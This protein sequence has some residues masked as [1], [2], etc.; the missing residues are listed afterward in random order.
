MKRTFTVAVATLSLALPGLL[1]ST[2]TAQAASGDHV[3]INEAYLNGGSGG[4]TYKNKY[5]ELYNPTD[6]AVSLTG[7]SLQ[8][9]SAS[10]TSG[11]SGV[12]ALSGSIP[13]KGY[14]VVAG[15]YNTTTP[16]GADWTASVTPDISTSVSWS[17]SSG[18]LIL[19]NVATT[20][21][22]TPGS[23]VSDTDAIVDLLG[24]GTS[25]TFETTA[26]CTPGVAVACA[27]TNGS[28][29]DVNATDFTAIGTFAPTN[30]LGVTYGDVTPPPPPPPP[31]ENNKTIAEIQ[32]NG[33]DSPLAGQTVTTTGFVTARYNTGGFAGYVIQTAGSGATID[34]TS[35]GLFVYSSATASAV[36]I[37]D[38]VKVTGA[39]SEFKGLTELTVNSGNM[40]KPDAT[41]LVPPVAATVTWPTTDTGREALES[42]LIAPQ[43]D[44]TV[45][46][47]YDT[48]YYASIGLAAGTE[49]LLI[50]TEVGRPG[51]AAYNKAIADNAAHAVTLD[52]GASTNFNSASNKSIPL[53]YLSLDKPVRVGAAVTFTAPVIVDYR[54]SLW[55]FQPT[56][57]L[58]VANADTVQP[59][60]FANTRTAAPEDVNGRLKI[61]SF[62]VLN[63]FTTTGEEA[64]AA[65]ATCTFYDD[66]A[67]N[68]ITVN[69]CD[70][71]GVRG[72]ADATNLARQQAK[73]VA[74][75]NALDAD[76]VSLE[77]IENA[78]IAGK[79]RD[80]AVAA[81]VDALNVAAG[82]T[83][84]AFAPS[85]A[86]IPAGEDVI[87]TAFIYNPNV[88]SLVGDSVIS[89][90]P[91]FDNARPSLAQGFAP[92]G[93]PGHAF[94]AVVNHFKSKGC[95]SPA[96]PAED[97]NA[98]QGDGQGCWN[99]SRVDQA[100][101]LVALAD[102]QKAA[103]GTD[104]VFLTGDFN[105]Y[106]QEDPMQV[107]YAAGFVD[108][109]SKTGKYTYSFDSQSG[110]LD[111]VLAS[112]AA[113]KIVSGADI[114]NI[115]SGE[116]I[117]LEYSRFNYNA[118]NF[119]DA[120]PFRSSDHDPEIV[121][122][123][124][125][126]T[127]LTLS[128][129]SVR[130]GTAVTATATVTGPQTGTVRFSVDGDVTDVPLV[131]GVATLT[132][133]NTLAVGDHQ[134]KAGYLIASTGA[135]AY[136]GPATFSVAKATV[137]AIHKQEWRIASASK[138]LTFTVETAALGDGVWA[139]GTLKTYLKGKVVA[140]T[141]L[142]AADQGRVQI[143]LPAKVLKSH[144]HGLVTIVTKL[145]D[146][147]T[148]EKATLKV[149]HVIL[150]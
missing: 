32:G 12:V 31:A 6:A 47:T 72:A 123:S 87:R 128:A 18:T 107:L 16:V 121:G 137:K 74:A 132:L 139:T 62:N 82:S 61:A 118:T 11:A 26:G 120:S 20:Q 115:N 67:G 79:P 84:W 149:L 15:N 95:P 88:V 85:P 10:G 143:T 33:A 41:G 108:Q 37:G 21:A 8:Y 63:Y 86:I 138:P 14:F 1:L 7:W 80:A 17:G 35:D 90:D 59:A 25:N 129:D 91:A 111:H 126:T 140:T 136:S 127:A 76:V 131:D 141:S 148:T 94:V 48:N 147:D 66:R 43:G 50:P 40:S 71:P 44:Y 60:T 28:D 104:T 112:A 24:Y 30:S 23:V 39:V 34:D 97:P 64:K 2:P 99:A 27:R 145:T 70:N 49:P 124:P 113:E 5:V 150:L 65:G 98:D 125:S 102:Q 55:N 103:I 19:A 89:A 93:E 3:V 142:T 52:D 51:S 68:H 105:S 116:S 146:S 77:E 101:A 42:M 133:P 92:V 130:Y 114:W 56:Q 45:T 106:T 83:R 117:A 57:Q 22:P 78:T 69:T 13:A 58:T 135:V 4:A 29:T 100:T 144:R 53:P 54:N 81:L 9:R 96:L 46:D 110:S 36:A 73:I 38:Y 119:Y 122:F 109:G 134:V 75:I